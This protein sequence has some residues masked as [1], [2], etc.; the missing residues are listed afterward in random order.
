[1]R[2]RCVWSVCFS[3]GGPPSSPLKRTYERMR[4]GGGGGE[5]REGTGC[6]GR[7]GGAEGG[8]KRR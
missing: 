8:C 6:E 1:M 7:G 5:V 3:R 4:G 2:R